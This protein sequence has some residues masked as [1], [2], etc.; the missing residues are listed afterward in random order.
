MAD[1]QFQK[2]GHYQHGG[3]RQCAGKLDAGEGAERK[4]GNTS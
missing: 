1:L 3:T 2:F 4:E